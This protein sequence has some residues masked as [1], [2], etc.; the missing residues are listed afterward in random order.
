MFRRALEVDRALVAEAPG[1]P[2]HRIAEAGV[3]QNLATWLYNNRRF[4]EAIAN[5]K[6]A[7][8]SFEELA[9]A[10][11]ADLARRRGLAM[12]LDTLGNAYL[13]SGRRAEAEEAYRRAS[14]AYDLLVSN[15]GATSADRL[16]LAACLSNRGSNQTG[17]KLPGAE[18]SLRRSLALLDALGS[19]GPASP[20]LRF[21]LAAARNNF[22]EWLASAGRPR[23]GGAR[24][25]GVDRALRRPGRP[26]SRRCSPTRRP[27]ARPG[28]NFG[29]FLVAQNRPDDARALLEEGIR[30]EQV[31]LAAG[32]EAREPLRKHLATLASLQ[33]DRKA[34]AEAAKAGE[35]LLKVATGVPSARLEVARLMARCAPLAAS[36]AALSPARRSVI[37]GAYADRA[38]ALLR[39]AIEGDDPEARRLLR[40]PAFDPI[41]DRDGFKALEPEKIGRVTSPGRSIL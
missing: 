10:D 38:I 1:V 13:T 26:S 35:E 37:A 40:D 29:Q 24:L 6:Q 19:E 27:S 3:L 32:P 25:Q 39:E 31:A 21:R 34:H 14:N 7:V 20:D 30:D 15:P 18:E 41:R 22:G 17:G 23:R 28:R 8:A 12:S 33:L 9:T 16:E 36:D 11:P 2:E 4:D 5:A